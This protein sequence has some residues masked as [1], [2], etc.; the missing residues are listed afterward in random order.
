MDSV[1]IEFGKGVQ[2]SGRDQ[3]W[4]YDMG[5]FYWRDRW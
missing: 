4:G 5:V 2:G 1:D 3:L